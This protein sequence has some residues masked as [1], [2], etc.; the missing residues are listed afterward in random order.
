MCVCEQVEIVNVEHY[1]IV[2]SVAGV[3]ETLKI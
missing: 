3:D 2:F 1:G